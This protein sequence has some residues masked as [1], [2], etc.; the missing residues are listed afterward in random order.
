MSQLFSWISC[1]YAYRKL[2]FEAS[3]AQLCQ[4]KN[5]ICR[6]LLTISQAF[7]SFTAGMYCIWTLSEF[8]QKLNMRFS[9]VPII[10]R[11]SFSE[12]MP[13]IC[14]KDTV[15]HFHSKAFFISKTLSMLFV[16][17]QL[18]NVFVIMCK[19]KADQ[20]LA[21][22]SIQCTSHLSSQHIQKG[23]VELC[24]LQAGLQ[25]KL[26]EVLSKGSVVIQKSKIL[27]GFPGEEMA[28]WL[29]SLSAVITL[30][31]YINF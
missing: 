19:L 11:Q 21:Q 18:K 31:K 14:R 20:H 16:F 23:S 2:I 8:I 15:L 10:A 3:A 30:V 4:N 13:S 26:N 28:Y 24:T 29:S 1:L 7:G 17:I 22:C 27:P 9:S 5:C 6:I 25:D 12:W